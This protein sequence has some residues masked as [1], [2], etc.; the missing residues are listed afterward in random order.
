MT[1]SMAPTVAE[2]QQVSM[3]AVRTKFMAMNAT[4][5]LV[6]AAQTRSFGKTSYNVPMAF[7]APPLF[8]S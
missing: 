2:A 3:P 1:G 6:V 5:L 7:I 4:K 8:F